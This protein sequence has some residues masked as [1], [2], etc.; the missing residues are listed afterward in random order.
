MSDNPTFGDSEFFDDDGKMP[1][2]AAAIDAIRNA[3]SGIKFDEVR[4]SIYLM[5]AVDYR[6][7]AVREEFSDQ[8]SLRDRLIE[9]GEDEWSNHAP[10]GWDGEVYK[11]MVEGYV[12]DALD[13]LDIEGF[14][15]RIAEPEQ[16]DQ[17]VAASEL[18]TP[19]AG[20]ILQIDLGE[21]NTELVRYLAAHPEKMRDLDP[22]KFEELVA[23]LFRDKGY[24][25]ELTPRSKDGGLDIR[26]FHKSALGRF[27]TLVE[28]KRYSERER[29]GVSIVRG[30]YGVVNMRTATS[31]LIATTS[32]FT[33][34]AK[35]EQQQVKERLHLAD[36]EELKGWLVSYR[37][38]RR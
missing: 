25:V 32:F 3:T 30:L 38:A 2:E 35:S 6:W 16:G 15:A 18:L 12:E 26:V 19:G 11:P 24:D 10:I 9:I 20:L 34:G 7:D 28:C 1:W 17:L 8:Y 36:F 23:E 29:V 33:K 27:L 4:A 13:D 14:F 5:S 22:R 21:I 37:G 31:G